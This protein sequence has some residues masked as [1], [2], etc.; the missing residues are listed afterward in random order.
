[1]G[2]AQSKPVLDLQDDGDNHQDDVVYMYCRMAERCPAAL[3]DGS[4]QGSDGMSWARRLET[5]AHSGYVFFLHIHF[6]CASFYL[7]RSLIADGPVDL[8]LR[9]G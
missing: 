4:A 6:G 8:D 9:A 1:M 3:M 7:A 2:S 5:G